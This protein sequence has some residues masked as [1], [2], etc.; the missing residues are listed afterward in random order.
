[1]PPLTPPTPQSPLEPSWHLQ[2]PSHQH[3]LLHCEHSF[4]PAPP[5]VSP[6]QHVRR[7]PLHPD[8]AK[9]R[10]ATQVKRI[11]PDLNRSDGK[12]NICLLS[13]LKR[14]ETSPQ[15]VLQQKN[16]RV[17]LRL[18]HKTVFF[19]KVLFQPPWVW[20]PKGHRARYQVP[21]S[22]RFPFEPGFILCWCGCFLFIYWLHCTVHVQ[23]LSPLTDQG[24]NSGPQA[25]KAQ[26]PKHRA[27][28]EALPLGALRQGR[29]EA[30]RSSPLAE[31]SATAR[32]TLDLPRP[33]SCQASPPRPGASEACQKPSRTGRFLQHPHNHAAEIT[34]QPP[35]SS[36]QKKKL[37]CVCVSVLNLRS[38]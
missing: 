15:L 1:M 30:R 38:K 12:I 36:L 2:P 26:S 9:V 37:T 22:F 35:Q 17:R 21:M 28:R 6:S 7:T 13:T 19:W 33:G 3:P 31:M 24:L 20:R 23:D 25:V 16:F 8:V 14:G 18:T 4:H 27:T 32:S 29:Q 34:P 10:P 5:P 11:K